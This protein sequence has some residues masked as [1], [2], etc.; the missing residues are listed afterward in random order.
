MYSLNTLILAIL[1]SSLLAAF[2][3]NNHGNRQKRKGV[4][5][6][7]TKSALRRVEMYYRV[8]RRLT[9]ESDDRALRDM[10]HEIQEENDYYLSLLQIESPWLGHA[11]EQFL[12]AL[13]RK[14][15]PLMHTAW[16]EKGKGP[17]AKVADGP[18]IKKYVNQFAKD[19]RR[20]FN[21]IMRPLQRGRYTLRKYF[22]ETVYES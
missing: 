17:G 2:A 21:P 16:E 20:L 8:R 12:G 11:Y 1:G 7:A 6:G 19:S 22:K 9:D 10:F 14:L 18:D 4:V 3:S 13:K 5:A 15:L